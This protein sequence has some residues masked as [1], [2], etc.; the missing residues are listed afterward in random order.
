MATRGRRFESCRDHVKP[1]H[2]KEDTVTR[3][4]QGDVI[5]MHGTISDSPI[6]RPYAPRPAR[7]PKHAKD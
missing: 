6:G 1:K 2:T 5:N 3:N 4:D 7:K